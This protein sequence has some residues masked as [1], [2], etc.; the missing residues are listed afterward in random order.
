MYLNRPDISDQTLATVAFQ[1][2]ILIVV[3]IKSVMLPVGV[4]SNALAMI[5]MTKANVYKKDV[6]PKKFVSLTLEF[7][8]IA[9]VSIGTH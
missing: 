5:Q 2:T 7:Q 3:R 8:V 9:L 1:E 4:G 6:L